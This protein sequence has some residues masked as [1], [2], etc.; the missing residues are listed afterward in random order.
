M[1]AALISGRERRLA[2]HGR[3]RLAGSRHPS[4]NPWMNS[5]DELPRRNPWMNDGGIGGAI[6]NG[7]AAPGAVRRHRGGPGE[8]EGSGAAPSPGPSAKAPRPS[9]RRG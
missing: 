6:I 7:A 5:L 3:G 1:G 4:P 2:K 9:G 8:C